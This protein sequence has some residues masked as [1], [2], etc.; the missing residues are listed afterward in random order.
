MTY[1]V[2]EPC[3]GKKER[4]CVEL[5]PQDAFYNYSDEE[6]N[7]KVGREPAESGDY[8]MLLINP[9]ECIHCG[10][11]ESECP[12]GAIVS[13]DDLPEKWAEY[14]EL[15]EKVFEQWSEDELDA[16]RVTSKGR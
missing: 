7:K 12:N 6:L 11:C 5:C 16:N 14:K 1:V 10:S 8:G 13:E 9:D 15:A 3:I 4:C 2:C